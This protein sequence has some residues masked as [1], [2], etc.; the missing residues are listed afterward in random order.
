MFYSKKK[1]IKK[2]EQ[3]KYRTGKDR[4]YKKTA[5]LKMKYI[6]HLSHLLLRPY[7]VLSLF[8]EFVSRHLRYFYQERQ[9]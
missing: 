6:L 1:F 3:K 4:Q 2:E 9:G 5:V 7:V 8:M